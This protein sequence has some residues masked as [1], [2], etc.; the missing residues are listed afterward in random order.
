M[1]THLQLEPAEVEHSPTLGKDLTSDGG[2]VARSITDPLAG[3]RN[4]VQIADA[5]H[6][7]PPA[8]GIA[9]ELGSQHCHS[10]E[11]QEPQQ[12]A[13]RR[14]RRGRSGPQQ[15][16]RRVERQPRP[17]HLERPARWRS[18]DCGAGGKGGQ[19]DDK[20]GGGDQ[21]PDE[22]PAGLSRKQRNEPGG[23]ARQRHPPGRGRQPHRIRALP[24]W[25]LARQEQAP[26]PFP[27]QED[28]SGKQS[29]DQRP[30]VEQRRRQ[31]RG[32]EGQSARAVWQ[33][34]TGRGPCHRQQ[35]QDPGRRR[36]RVQRSG[37]PPG[38]QHQEQRR[39]ERRPGDDGDSA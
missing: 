24:A 21:M 3:Q 10:N 38:R 9:G 13:H 18:P 25:Q 33:I 6:G 32:T 27:Q 7:Q 19:G 14:G 8:M 17:Q 20:A 22:G 36:D 30:E 11:R 4:L 34:A 35:G 16:A 2:E 1:L 23:A 5:C 15:P 39:G 29:A 12:P 28:G 37:A 31:R 26:P